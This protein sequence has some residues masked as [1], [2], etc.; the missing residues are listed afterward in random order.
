MKHI[1]DILAQNLFQL[2]PR[3]DPIFLVLL[4]IAIIENIMLVIYYIKAKQY[5]KQLDEYK[6]QVIK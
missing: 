2:T 4:A 5:R 6:H 1:L 3:L